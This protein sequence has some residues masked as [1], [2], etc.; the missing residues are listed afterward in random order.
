MYS[1]RMIK[2]ISHVIINITVP[3][4]Y[5]FSNRFKKQ[6]FNFSMPHTLKTKFLNPNFGIVALRQVNYKDS[7][8][9][10]K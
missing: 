4:I 1:E 2:I 7:C 6:T 8:H 5:S 10:Y 3:I 9:S